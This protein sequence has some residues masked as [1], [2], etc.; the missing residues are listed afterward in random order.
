MGSDTIIMLSKKLRRVWW[1][2]QHEGIATISSIDVP[3]RH[4]VW[5]VGLTTSSREILFDPLSIKALLTSPSDLWC[6]NP[7]LAIPGQKA[8]LLFTKIGT[9]VADWT[10]RCRWPR[11]R[12]PALDYNDIDKPKNTFNTPNNAIAQRIPVPGLSGGKMSASEENSK[13]DLLDSSHV[14]KRKFKKAFCEPTN[15][16]NNS[17]LSIVEYIIFPLCCPPK[18]SCVARFVVTPNEFRKKET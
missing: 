1:E 8:Q 4:E 13:I 10:N 17:L 16:T 5:I 15:I 7:L 14:V 9:Q 3:A 12:I 18:G 6:V 2:N 11:L